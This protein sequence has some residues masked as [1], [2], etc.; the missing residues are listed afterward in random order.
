VK[1]TGLPQLWNGNAKD[2]FRHLTIM[3]PCARIG[4][5]CQ[6]KNAASRN[7]RIVGLLA[8]TMLLLWTP[9]CAQETVRYQEGITHGF[10]IL[11]DEQGNAIAEGDLMQTAH[12]D[13]VSS[14]LVFHFKD[15]SVDDEFTTFSQRGK[16]RLLTDRHI[17]KGP[18]FKQP[19]DV[20]IDG[21]RGQVVVQTEEKD[22]K[23]KT[24]AAHM[25]LPP[26]LANG[27]LF[28]LLRNLGPDAAQATFSLLVAMP[29]LRLVKLMANRAGE[30]SLA[31]GNSR[32]KAID[33]ELKIQL[34]GVS[35]TIAPLIGKQPPDLHIWILRNEVPTFV[36]FR[37]PLFEGGPI[38]QID[39]E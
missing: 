31:I 4:L 22:G 5:V 8:L 20:R 17:Q 27:I 15:G 12:G 9:A 3:F 13:R 35:K 32:R 38:W 18:S 19:E 33:Y 16:F 37:G 14:R 2:T 26:D 39:L 29:K 10:L 11:R 6:T 28:T 25:A 7:L 23:Q 21:A 34:R 36:R 30:D 1:W 24:I